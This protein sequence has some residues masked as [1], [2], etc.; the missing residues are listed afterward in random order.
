MSTILVAEPDDDVRKTVKA[1]LERN[2]HT[3]YAFKSAT[4]ALRF[5]EEKTKSILTKAL[6]PKP[7]EPCF[8]SEHMRVNGGTECLVDV[9]I[10]DTDSCT[11]PIRTIVARI[12]HRYPSVASI[13]TYASDYE[14]IEDL[15]VQVLAKP[16]D[17]S[18]LI[19]AVRSSTTH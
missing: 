15:P 9:V 6:L 10:L 12:Q 19:S 7:G 2:G 4:D 13:V 16:F 18:A 8:F 5:L 14:P 17:P 11:F 3:V 1:I